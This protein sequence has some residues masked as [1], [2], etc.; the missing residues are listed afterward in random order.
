MDQPGFVPLLKS[1]VVVG[2]DGGSGGG[3]GGDGG[4]GGGEGG[5]GDEGGGDGGNGGNTG[6][7]AEGGRNGGRGGENA[8]QQPAQSHPRTS[9]SP[10][11]SRPFR[12]P[13]VVALHPMSQLGVS[14]GL[15]CGGGGGNECDAGGG[16]VGGRLDAALAPPSSARSMLVLIRAGS[17]EPGAPS[18]GAAAGFAFACISRPPSAGPPAHGGS[19]G[20][21]VTR[22]QSAVALTRRLR[23]RL[24]H[25]G[26]DGGSDTEALMATTCSSC[27]LIAERKVQ[28]CYKSVSAGMMRW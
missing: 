3:D 26:S 5:E 17:L 28:G 25:G 11:C 12:A 6:C 23:R 19:D 2:C 10:H 24:R 8:V 21:S 18:R 22:A 15:G 9:S 16:L 13:Q 14:S 1:K 20:G 27:R 7:G 4:G